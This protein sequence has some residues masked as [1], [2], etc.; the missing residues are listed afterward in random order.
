MLEQYY[1]VGGD[2]GYRSP[3]S[4]A[5][6]VN[7]TQLAQLTPALRGTS[8]INALDPYSKVQA[9][10]IWRQSNVEVSGNGD[11]YVTNTKSGSWTSLKDASFRQRLPSAQDRPT[12]LQ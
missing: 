1:G 4:D 11:S 2:G 3:M 8:Q 5:V 9:E 12:G 6:T 7:G 10:T